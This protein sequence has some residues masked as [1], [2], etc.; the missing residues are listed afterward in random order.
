MLKWA[1]PGANS[2]IPCGVILSD[3]LTVRMLVPDYLSEHSLEPD[4]HSALRYSKD[5]HFWEKR[6]FPTNRT[7]QR[8]ALTFFRRNFTQLCRHKNS[9]KCSVHIFSLIFLHLPD[10]L[11]IIFLR[12]IVEKSDFVA[13]NEELNRVEQL[14]TVGHGHCNCPTV[15]LDRLNFSC[16]VIIYQNI[17]F[18]SL[19]R[20]TYVGLFCLIKI[21][22]KGFIG[23]KD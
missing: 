9:Q 7:S 14:R 17:R 21:W 3:S 18:Y 1:Q 13:K 6:A 4:T 15:L 8:V 22:H 12:T 20:S 16:P 2:I 5:D 23:T 10:V 19:K 11:E